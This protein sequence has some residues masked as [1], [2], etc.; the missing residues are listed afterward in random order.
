MADGKKISAKSTGR[1]V[2]ARREQGKANQ[3]LQDKLFTSNYAQTMRGGAVAD[4]K[5]KG[6]KAAVPSPAYWDG[7]RRKPTASEKA[8]NKAFGRDKHLAKKGK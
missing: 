2:G 4:A 1:M 5:S 7:S 8:A 6:M 3:K